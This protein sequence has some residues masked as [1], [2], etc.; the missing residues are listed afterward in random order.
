V[1][2]QGKK[3]TAVLLSEEEL[4]DLLKKE[5]EEEEEAEERELEAEEAEAGKAVRV[6]ENEETEGKDKKLG[7]SMVTEKEVK[8]QDQDQ[9][10][11]SDDSVKDEVVEEVE[12]MSLKKKA[13]RPADK[14][15][16]RG[17]EVGL[18]EET[19]S[20][21]GSEIPA[22]LDYAADSGILQPVE[23][24]SAKIDPSSD[25]TQSISKEDIPHNIKKGATEKGVLSIAED[26]DQEM[27]YIEA[28]DREEISISEKEPKSNV[29]LQ[30]PKSSAGL[31]SSSPPSGKEDE[32]SKND[33]GMNNKGKT[34]K[35]KK[36]QRAK[37]HSP[38]MDESYPAQEQNQQDPMESEGSSRE[39]T[40]HKAK[41]RRAGKWVMHL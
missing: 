34:R 38:Q 21:T 39:N 7:K 18:L 25:N 41:R 11:A 33:S 28:V 2:K 10:E 15:S 29:D 27:Q 8:D 3:S 31:E 24:E 36:K 32:K 14:K 22:D 13:E 16:D 4:V 30:E 12:K 26:Y 9:E 23:I 35:Q 5:A 6:T 37:K 40:V 17:E 1:P 19:E 20:S